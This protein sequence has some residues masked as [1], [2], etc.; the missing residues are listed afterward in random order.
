MHCWSTC[1]TQVHE[2]QAQ[3]AGLS[4]QLEVRQQRL[5]AAQTAADL[6]VEQVGAQGIDC[7]YMP[8]TSPV[9]FPF[10]LHYIP[11]ASQCSCL[12]LEQGSTHVCDAANINVLM[13]LAPCSLSSSRHAASRPPLCHPATPLPPPPSAPSSRPWPHGCSPWSRPCSRR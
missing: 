4:S 1:T 13:P 7:V 11:T 9:R 12:M 3:V 8:G 2:L 10:L 5:E 6:A